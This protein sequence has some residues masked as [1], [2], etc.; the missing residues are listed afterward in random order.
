[1]SASNIIG[2]RNSTPEASSSSLR[3][4]S[5]RTLGAGHH[6]RASADMGAFTAQPP[7]SARGI[8]PAS[9]IYLNHFPQQGANS[10]NQDDAA[11][12]AA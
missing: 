1:M 9:E 5:S 10:G 3:P 6:L 12:K 2:N 8:R 7:L 11:E 4:P